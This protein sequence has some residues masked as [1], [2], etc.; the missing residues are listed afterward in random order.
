[1]TTPHTQDDFTH[2]EWDALC[3]C[4]L[5]RDPMWWR[6]LREVCGYRQGRQALRREIECIVDAWL[7][8]HPTW[9]GRGMTRDDVVR[10]CRGETV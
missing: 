10:V 2:D 3:W 1:M 7:A 9:Q 8:A 5:H 6:V 4:R